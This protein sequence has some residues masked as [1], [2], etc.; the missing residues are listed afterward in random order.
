MN[1][2]FKLLML[3]ELCSIFENIYYFSKK[4][5]TKAKKTIGTNDIENLWYLQNCGI[6]RGKTF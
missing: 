4:I 2:E 3:F 1:W 6:E 5:D